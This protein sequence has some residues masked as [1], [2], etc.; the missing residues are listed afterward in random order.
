MPT[1]P[2]PS[3][4]LGEA[5]AKALAQLLERREPRVQVPA[6]DFLIVGKREVELSHDVHLR[7][8]AFMP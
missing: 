2:N 4:E 8:P 3:Q 1:T 6:L 7:Q 5:Y